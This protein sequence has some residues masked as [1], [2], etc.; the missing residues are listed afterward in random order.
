ML[1]L[2]E[3]FTTV[4]SD[5]TKQWAEKHAGDKKVLKQINSFAKVVQSCR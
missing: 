4:L 1:L 2:I 3:K 5:P